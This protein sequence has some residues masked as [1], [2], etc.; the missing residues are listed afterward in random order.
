VSFP[1]ANS[2]YLAGLRIV[3]EIALPSLMACA[4]QIGSSVSIRRAR[5]PETLSSVTAVFPEGQCNENEVLFNI[6]DAARYLIRS[7]S[8]ILVDQ[9]ANSNAGDVVAYLLGTAFGVL[10][11]QRGTCPLHGSAIDTGDGCVAFVGDSG[12][13]KSTMVAAL[14]SRGHQVISD[15]LCVFEAGQQG[16]R[17]WPGLNRLR[18]WE[19]ALAALGCDQPGIERE[20]RGLNKYLVPTQPIRNPQ[21]PRRL[22]RVYQLAAA[23]DGDPT[24]LTRLHGAAALEVLMQNIYRLAIAERM[25]RKAKLFVACAAAARQVPVYRLSR[26]LGFQIVPDVLK[27]LEEHLHELR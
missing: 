1:P 22:L 8:E 7:G 19:D 3:S 12:S 23:A 26:P 21:N 14:A 9:A 11:H 27:V 25:G 5:L 10:C 17:V 4:D 2:Y 18:L 20:F 16:V 6:P 24:T 13:G 15:D